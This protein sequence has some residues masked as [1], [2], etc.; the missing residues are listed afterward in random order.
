MRFTTAIKTAALGVF[1]GAYL[2]VA[3]SPDSLGEGLA[4]RKGRA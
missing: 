1:G 4:K 3:S 2:D